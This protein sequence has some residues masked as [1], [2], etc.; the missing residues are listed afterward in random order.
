MGVRIHARVIRPRIGQ[1]GSN[2]A[3]VRHHL[4]QGRSMSHVHFL[5]EPVGDSRP[6]DRVP[7]GSYLVCSVDDATDDTTVILRTAD[8]DQANKLCGWLNG[9]VAER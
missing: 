1:D 2:A 4:P 3:G 5:N 8:R 9:A 6:S 7:A